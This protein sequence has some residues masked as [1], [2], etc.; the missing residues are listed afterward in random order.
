MV[1]ML[2]V[3]VHGEDILEEKPLSLYE[4]SVYVVY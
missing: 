2:P 3:Q 4:Y 1:E